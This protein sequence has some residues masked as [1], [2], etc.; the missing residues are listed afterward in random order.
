MNLIHKIK[1]SPPYISLCI[2]L[3]VYLLVAHSTFTLG[4]PTAPIRKQSQVDIKDSLYLENDT[5]VDGLLNECY[6]K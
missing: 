4:K 6:S 2:T 5:C 1:H 3:H